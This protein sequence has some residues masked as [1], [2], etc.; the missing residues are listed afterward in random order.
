MAARVPVLHWSQNVDLLIAIGVV[1]VVLMIIIPLPSVMLDFFI[2]VN[3]MLSVVVLLT[4]MYVKRALDFSVF[5]SLLLI[6]TVFRLALNVS[7][8]RL[9]L[10]KGPAFN[11]KI[12]KA[13][14][15]FVVG[16]NYVV[17]FIIFII[18]VIVQ[19]I[20]ITKGANRVSEV[21][22]RFTLDAMPGKQMAIDAD[23][24]AGLITEEEARKRREEIRK[25]ADFY[26]AMDGAAKFI[27]GDVKAS[28][29]ITLIDIIGGFIIGVAMRKESFST[30][31]K[32][33]TLLTIGDGLVSQ[34]PALIVSTA[35]GIIVTRAASDKNLGGDIAK[36]ISTQPRAIFIGSGL[37]LI[38]SIL[39]GFPTVPLLLL[40]A[41]M[42]FLGFQLQKLRRKKEEEE[43][44]KKLEKEEAEKRKP[45]ALRQL[46]H[47]DP[48]EIEIGYNL[49]PLVDP[50]QGGDLL[51]RITMIRRQIALELGLLVPPIRIRDNM[52]LKPE[53]YVILLKGVEV[54]RGILRPDKYM[55]M[56]AEG[57]I[58]DL[59]GEP[60]KEPA[61]GLPA[62]WIPESE[63]NKAELAGYTV[64]DPPS[65]IATHLAEIIKQYGYELLGRQEVNTLLD[66]IKE[67]SPVLVDEVLK[68]TNIGTIQKV[69]Q[70][71]LKERVSI[72]DLQTILE[73]IADYAATARNIDLL[74][75]YVRIA[76]RRQISRTY[77]VDG[78]IKVITFDPELETRINESIQ[79][80]DEGLVCT[81]SP[82]EINQIIK[83]SQQAVNEAI[84]PGETPVFLTSMKIRPIVY[85]I[86]ARGIPGAVVL[87][88]N[89]LEPD[90][91]IENLKVVSI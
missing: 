43:E 89:E 9:I 84:K 76:L 23:L 6:L 2:A 33:Y 11:V 69:L 83:A 24:N 66:N 27:Q 28:L 86:L 75:E 16:G 78:K 29:A 63:R 73:A 49:I 17:G 71:L 30:A 59:K 82:Q 56:A 15:D 21:A 77:T 7:S 90:V 26:G 52:R 25:E 18:I 61:F 64:V 45:S 38:L 80:T 67:T 54:G 88:Y 87:S 74:T 62:M 3:L 31:A 41:T 20:V 42:G 44:R 10:L 65:V 81:L 50:Q 5:P 53:E 48:L 12:I 58:K 4:A 57:E 79:E 60:T 91:Y 13:F 37:L 22:A 70:N 34:L 68:V 19:F 14:G 32:T 1:T 40:G 85:D 46:I 8:T 35:T 39:P 51:E 72:R 55:V 36:Q 47:V